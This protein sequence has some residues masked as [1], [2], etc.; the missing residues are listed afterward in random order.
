MK[1]SAAPRCTVL[2]LAPYEHSRHR[3][4][5]AEE[6]VSI[7]VL[8]AD[9]QSYGLVVSEIYDTEEIVVKPLGRQLQSQSHYAGATIMGDGKVALI[10]DA[11]G[12]AERSGVFCQKR[13]TTEESFERVLNADRS[14][15]EGPE[16]LLVFELGER[17]RFALPMRQAQRLE[18]FAAERVEWTANGPV[19]Q[20]RDGVL[21]LWSVA[22]LLR[23]DAEMAPPFAAGAPLQVVVVENQGRLI[24][25]VVRRILDIVAE[26]CF[27][28]P[29]EPGLPLLGSAILQGQ[30][31]DLIDLSKLLANRNAAF[32]RRSDCDSN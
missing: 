19:A 2:G 31:T 3:T 6:S 22:Q 17:G 32:L 16:T 23:Q 27:L 24:G 12:I 1:I 15:S 29:S 28:S 25:L 20:Y 5:G 7:V 13:A 10:L 26:D 11:A 30:V 8:E 21:P 14:R 9:G 18:E 4:T